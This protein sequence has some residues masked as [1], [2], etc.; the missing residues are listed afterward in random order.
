MDTLP[1]VEITIPAPQV[2]RDHRG[3]VIGR[4]EGQRL[5]GK[6]VIRDHRG[7]LLGSY[8]P[9]ADETR[10]KASYTNLA[11]AVLAADT[12][13]R[14]GTLRCP[15]LIMAGR[16]DPICSPLATRW[17]QERLPQAETIFF[18][19]SSHFFLMEEPEKA[20]ETLKAW[21]SRHSR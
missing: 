14:L 18:E 10:D 1:A 7:V 17:M 19:K 15:T 13:E 3:T 20:I 4:I 21:L 9:R 6:V 2:L 12:L 5:T 8:D 11:N 16:K